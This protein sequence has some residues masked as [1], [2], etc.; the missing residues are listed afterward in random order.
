MKSLLQSKKAQIDFPIVGLIVVAVFL[1]ITAPFI[2]KM[3]TSLQSSLSPAFGN[4]SGGEIAQQN[5]NYVFST[6]IN[7]MD[8]VVVFLFFSAVLLMLI[9]AFFIDAH[10]LFV[11]LYIFLAFITV[12]FV[13]DIMNAV[14][15]IYNSSTFASEVGYLTFTIALKDHFMAFLIGIIFLT[16]VIIYGKIAFF[17]SSG[18]GGNRP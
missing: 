16:G 3:F 7:F 6:G 13:P 10:P 1:M 17:P 12:M 11:V 18:G 14:D 5:V 9:S 4:V 2:L 8:K 15:N